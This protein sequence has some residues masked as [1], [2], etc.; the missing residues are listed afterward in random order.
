NFAIND[1]MIFIEGDKIV[2]EPGNSDIVLKNLHVTDEKTTEENTAKNSI[3]SCI[4]KTSGDYSSFAETLLNP[5]IINNNILLVFAYNY[6]DST[7]IALSKN[8]TGD[9]NNVPENIQKISL[10]D[11][12]S[13]TRKRK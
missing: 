13:W 12:I 9:F 7:L 11:M 8:K 10:A 6:N 2:K 5:E 4:I 3:L 1:V